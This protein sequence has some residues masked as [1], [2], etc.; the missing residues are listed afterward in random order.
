VT[1]TNIGSETMGFTDPITG[2]V[3]GSLSVYYDDDGSQQQFDGNGNLLPPYSRIQLANKPL[4]TPL[5][6][7]DQTDIFFTPPT[8]IKSPFNY[9]VV[10]QG[11]LGAE[12]GA[13]SGHVGGSLQIYYRADDHDLTDPNDVEKI[14]RID[15]DGQ[16]KT[17]VYDNKDPNVGIEKMAVSPDQTQL[18]FTQRDIQSDSAIIN[19]LNIGTGKVSALPGVDRVWPSWSPDGQRI[20]FEAT[21]L[22]CPPQCT[23]AEVIFIYD[24]SPQGTTLLTPL[25]DPNDLGIVHG[26]ARSPA[27]S[28]NGN[29][30]A[31]SLRIDDNPKLP[32]CL[33]NR[34]IA[35]VDLL[36]NSQRLTC[37]GSGASDDD[38]PTWSPDGQNI[39]F[40]RTTGSGTGP[41]LYKVSINGGPPTQLTDGGSEINP[42]WSA[43]NN[44]IA[45]ASQRSGNLD[46]W[47]VDPN[48]GS[49]VRDLTTDN[50][51]ANDF[52]AF[53]R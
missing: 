10:F 48:T 17:L 19:I 39:I 36:S 27:W 41:F 25:P 22:A 4:Q 21:L 14:Y 16:N 7:G 8:D 5:N 18:A 37:D 13:V 45:V 34:V 40:S 52:P 38:Y 35:V 33:N 20:A 29:L 53:A 43:Y 32:G 30:I 50:P 24:F 6:P 1:V 12:T 49:F 26:D 15:I 47:L 9:V 46:I 42:T 3:N 44:L 31:Y 28:P 23:P 11:Q 2:Q 51:F